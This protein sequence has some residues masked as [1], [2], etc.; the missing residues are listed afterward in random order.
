MK[1]NTLLVGYARVDITP[2]SSV[3]LA[4]YG[5]TSMRMS[6]TIRDELYASCFAITDREENTIL[7][8][9]IDLSRITT[10]EAEDVRAAAQQRFGIPAD[11]V[12]IAGTHTHSAPDL[13]NHNHPAIQQ[14]SKLLEER[15]PVC[16]ELAMDDRCHARMFVGDVEATGMNFV[17][18]YCNVGADGTLRYFGDNFGTEVLDDTTAHAT[19]ADPTMHIVKF[20][21]EGA[22]DLVLVNWRAHATLSGGQKRYDVSADFIGDFR[23]VWEQ[24]NDSLLTYFQGAAGNINP[25]SRI[26]SEVRTED[27]LAYG[28]ILADYLAEG[29]KSVREMAVSPIRVRQVVLDCPINKPTPELLNHA[30]AVTEFWKATNDLKACIDFGLPKGIRSPYMANAIRAR[31]GMPD[32]K[33]IELGAV[34]LGD[35]AFITTPNELFDAIS[36]YVEENA[37]YSKVMAIGYCNGYEGYIPSA[38]GFAYTCYETDTCRFYPEIGEEFQNQLLQMLHDLKNSCGDE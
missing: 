29:L 20:V 16:V 26:R 35:L 23:R 28:R 14:Y 18:H 5:N 21:R 37:P 4:G 2:Q 7:L 31:A 1:N 38:E 27:S 9:S 34:S 22:A 13:H 24:N 12:F 15:L 11:H 8:M 30:N 10:K 32:S 33:H 6:R 17:R 3:P 36:V 19:D 25:K